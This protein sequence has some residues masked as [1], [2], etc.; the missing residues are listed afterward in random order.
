MKSLTM[1]LL[2]VWWSPVLVRAGA[3]VVLFK[4]LSKNN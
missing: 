4:V 1:E 3:T 2:L